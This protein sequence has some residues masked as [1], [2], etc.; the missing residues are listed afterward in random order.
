MVQ[1]LWYA[2]RSCLTMKAGWSQP[3]TEEGANLVVVVVVERMEG[4]FGYITWTEN[5]AVVR[6]YDMAFESSW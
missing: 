5:E 6:L 1:A 2:G 3:P 4:N